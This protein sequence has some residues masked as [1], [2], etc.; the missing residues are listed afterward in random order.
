MDWNK[1]NTILITAF[2]I[3][4]IF[5][6]VSSGNMIR[7]DY[8]PNKDK[9]FAQEVSELLDEK[10]IKINAVIPAETYT[11]PVLDTEYEIIHIDS[12]FLEN[13]LHE[14]IE[15][16]ED[17]YKYSN[18]KGEILEVIDGK[19][20]RLELRSGVPGKIDGDLNIKEKIE[21]FIKDYNIDAGGYA[22]NLK[23]I[24]ENRCNYIYTKRYNDYSVENSYMKFFADKEGIYKFEMQRIISISEITEKIRTIHAIE[25]LPRILTYPEIKNKEIAKIEMTYYSVEDENWQNIERINSDPTWKVIFSDGTQIHLPGIE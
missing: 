19:K 3:L 2:L 6:F 20:L 8:N 10:N 4:N 21:N 23:H 25:A 15:P 9:E 14:K 7:A 12:Q 16:L 17:V 1:T 24:S 5:L 22:E 11:L 18:K 13:F